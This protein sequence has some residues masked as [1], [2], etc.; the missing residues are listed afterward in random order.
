M[1]SLTDS[2]SSV[3]VLQGDNLSPN[4]FKLFVNDLLYIFDSKCMPVSLNTSKINCLMYANNDVIILY[5]TPT[6]LQNSL[7]YYTKVLYK[8]GS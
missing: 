6:G 3:W 5:E 8:M 7:S 1:S 2:K 4:L